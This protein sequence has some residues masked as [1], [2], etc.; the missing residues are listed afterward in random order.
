M[1]ATLNDKQN[2]PHDVIEISPDVV[3]ASRTHQE[4]PTL[5]PEIGGRAEPKIELA[6]DTAVNPAPSVDNAVRAALKDYQAARKRSSVGKWLRGAMF[7]MLFA[8]ASA[9]AA[10]AWGVHGNAVKQTVAA[11]MPAFLVTAAPSQAAQ[12]AADQPTVPASQAEAADQNA[13][14]AAA[15]VQKLDST[16]ATDSAAPPDSAQALQSMTRDLAAMGQQI[17]QLKAN[18]AELKAGQ[19]QMAREMSRPAQARPAEAR[20]VDPRAKLS[21]LPPRPLAAAAPV[22]KPKPVHAPAY[23]PAPVAPLPPPSQAAAVPPS[24]APAPQLTAD[25]DGPVVRPPMPVR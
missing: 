16:A 2:D 21:A 5:A 22:R 12:A 23:A 24:P 1:L 13:P 19:E 11:W 18:I 25:D 10:I 20:S 8:G 7:S 14:Q 3:L 9:A 6:S 15:L 17:E 4:A